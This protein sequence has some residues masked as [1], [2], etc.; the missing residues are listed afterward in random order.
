MST[1]Q[2]DKINSFTPSLPVEINDSFKVT[3]S[4]QFTGSVNIQAP[5]QL[6]GTSASFDQLNLTSGNPNIVPGTISGSGFNIS[7]TIT[8]NTGSFAGGLIVNG[9]KQIEGG[10]SVFGPISASG[11]MTAST[12]SFGAVIA[13]SVSASIVYGPFDGGNVQSTTVDLGSATEFV[14]NG[15]KIQLRLTLGSSIADGAQ[16]GPFLLKSNKITSDSS[17]IANIA[18]PVSGGDTSNSISASIVSTFLENNTCSIF[19]NNETGQTIGANTTFT[20]SILV[21]R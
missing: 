4:S 5:H 18:G 12:G 11:N 3:G 15:Q 16:A 1:L 17:V 10:I 14:N 20:C 7:S 13:T 21:I 6:T 8:G 9:G 2:V 19:L